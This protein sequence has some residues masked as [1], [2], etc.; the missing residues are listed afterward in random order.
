MNIKFFDL[1]TRMLDKYI[2]IPDERG[3]DGRVDDT[4][5]IRELMKYFGERKNNVVGSIQKALK[6]SSDYNKEKVREN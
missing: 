3:M 6:K 5:E 2:N 4:S 1:F